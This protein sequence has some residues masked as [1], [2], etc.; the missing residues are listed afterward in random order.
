MSLV[1]EDALLNKA[2]VQW[3]L[4]NA[5][6]VLV[7]DEKVEVFGACEVQVVLNTVA[8]AANLATGPTRA[9]GTRQV[10][11]HAQLKDGFEDALA[12]LW[13]PHMDALF[14]VRGKAASV[15][16]IDDAVCDFRM[17]CVLANSTIAKFKT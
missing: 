7:E 6:Q 16:I 12:C 17:I 3:N 5:V 8:D 10:L 14:V 15:W 4:A 9:L 1:H 11:R 2:E 13:V